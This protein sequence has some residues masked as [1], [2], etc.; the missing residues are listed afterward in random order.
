[1]SS[2][3][4]R[5]EPLAP[6][7]GAEISGIQ[8]SKPLDEHSAATVRQA[9]LDWKVIF[10]RDQDVSTEEHIEFSRYF[11]ELEVHPFGANKEGYPEVLMLENGPDR[12][13]H[14][15]V[16][17]SDVTWR[18]EPSLGS[19]LLEFARHAFQRI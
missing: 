9:L 13:S 12:K 15:N 17:H 1:M 18:R 19:L 5:V 8:M 3:A 7:I 16:W 2:D 14:I 10:F 6:S 11:G 4:I